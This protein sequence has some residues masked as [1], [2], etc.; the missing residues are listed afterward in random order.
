[1]PHPPSRPQWHHRCGM[2]IPL[3]SPRVQR[4]VPPVAVRSIPLIRQ[5]LLTRGAA[6]HHPPIRMHQR[7]LRSHEKS[8]LPQSLGVAGP[9]RSSGA[10]SSSEERTAA[11]P[12]SNKEGSE[13][14]AESEAMSAAA[15][16]PPTPLPAIAAEPKRMLRKSAAETSALPAT[17][18]GRCSQRL[19]R[20][21]VRPVLL[22][23]SADDASP[24]PHCRLAAE[25]HAAAAAECSFPPAPPL[26]SG[27]GGG[28]YLTFSFDLEATGLDVLTARILD[29]AVVDVESGR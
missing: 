22:S 26:S 10:A 21:T 27:G 9:P 24:Q 28:G 25:A 17:V 13:L 2:Q 11:V 7:T 8:L 14:A 15:A 12:S 3:H 18:G 23:P 20:L 6:A 16:S 5:S 4:Q 29:I 19:V 1:M